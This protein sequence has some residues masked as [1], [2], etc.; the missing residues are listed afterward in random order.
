MGSG[1][2][3]TILEARNYQALSRA[4]GEHQLVLNLNAANGAS[5][6]AMQAMAAGAAVVSDY[7]PLLDA[8]FHAKSAIEFFDRSRIADTIQIVG[9]LLQ[10]SKGEATAE[11]GRALVGQEHRW[12]D[13]AARIIDVARTA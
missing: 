6:R 5:E 13:K 4:Y 1:S 10:S 8:A 7:N 12:E 2:S 9:E 3:V 11:R